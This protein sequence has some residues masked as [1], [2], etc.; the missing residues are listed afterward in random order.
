LNQQLNESI[1]KKPTSFDQWILRLTK[2]NI[3]MKFQKVM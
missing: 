2:I 1:L 3:Q